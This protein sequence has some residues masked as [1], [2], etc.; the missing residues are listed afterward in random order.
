MRIASHGLAK[1]AGPAAGP[2][3]GADGGLVTLETPVA[4]ASRLLQT[5]G[6]LE[7]GLFDGVNESALPSQLTALLASRTEAPDATA[8]AG[9]VRSP[10]SFRGLS[11]LRT[12]TG[13]NDTT[14]V[15]D[16]DPSFC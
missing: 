13:M 2:K 12:A 5:N 3:S 8:G 4:S 6:R 10:P 11:N 15:A 1:G 16:A 14:T 7:S 9:A